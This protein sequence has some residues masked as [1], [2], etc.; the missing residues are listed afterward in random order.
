MIVFQEAMFS[1]G[2]QF[3]HHMTFLYAY[4][5][6]ELLNR[7]CITDLRFDSIRKKTGIA[8]GKLYI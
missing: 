6:L 7:L 5:I 1:T 4:I 8:E 2:R 3:N